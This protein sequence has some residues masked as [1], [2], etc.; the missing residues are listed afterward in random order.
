MVS[1]IMCDAM[2]RFV[3]E[4]LPDFGSVK[5][6]VSFTH[7]H[8]SHCTGVGIQRSRNTMLLL[9]RLAQVLDEVSG[10]IPCAP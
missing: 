6:L 10:V 1:L 3:T 4:L 5:C 2:V 8:G 9:A 7:K